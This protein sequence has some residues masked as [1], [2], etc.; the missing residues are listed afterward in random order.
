MLIMIDKEWLENNT[1]DIPQFTIEEKLEITNK[2]YIEIMKYK[3]FPQSITTNQL[4]SITNFREC[5]L[6]LTKN[7]INF[8]PN[9]EYL[10]QTLK[11]LEIS[12]TWLVK[13]HTHSNPDDCLKDLKIKASMKIVKKTFTDKGIELTPEQERDFVERL[14]KNIDKIIEE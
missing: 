10:E 3:Y 1:K 9:N 7:I 4:D 11:H 6:E 5:Y 2:I 13:A 12:L 14:V 8:T